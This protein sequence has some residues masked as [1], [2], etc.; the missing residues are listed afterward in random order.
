MNAT[1]A[2]FR[3]S[4]VVQLNSGGPPMTVISV[5]RNKVLTVAWFD[6]NIF[7][8]ADFPSECVH[9]AIPPDR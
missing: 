6:G 9:Y 4:D 7:Y 8:H 5:A 1:D 3:E 2:V